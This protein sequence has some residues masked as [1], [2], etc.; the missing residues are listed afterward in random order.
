MNELQ[1]FN[2]PE[3]GEVR[4]VKVEGKPYAVGI[5][6]AGP[7]GYARPYEAISTH[8]RGAVTYRVTDSLGREQET[9]VIPE[10]DIYRLIVKAA[11][12]SKNPEISAK[13]ERFERWIFDEVIPT[14]RKTGRYEV[15]PQ[16][17][18]E[19]LK[20]AYILI[21]KLNSPNIGKGAQ[22]EIGRAIA[23]AI[24]LSG[25]SSRNQKLLLRPGEN[26]LPSSE[27]SP[28][29]M[30]IKLLRHA[31][32]MLTF[33]PRSEKELKSS[34]LRDDNFYYIFPGAVERYIGFSGARKGIYGEIKFLDGKSKIK[35]FNFFGNKPYHVWFLPRRTTSWMDEDPRKRSGNI[36]AFPGMG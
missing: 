9:K 30:L 27:I 22:K 1:I 2:N 31:E 13:A 20:I 34:V 26:Y 25:V 3:F 11:D 32:P 5:D 7:L 10:G 28:G 8:C 14:I 4:W 24:K 18:N 29:D 23:N 16:V 35:K 19:H 12:Q 15:S 17:T 6:I 36:I 21:D 33:Q